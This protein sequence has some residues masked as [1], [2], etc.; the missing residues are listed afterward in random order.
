MAPFQISRP[1]E[2]IPASLPPIKPIIRIYIMY[3]QNC[4]TNPIR[5]IDCYDQFVLL[6]TGYKM[7]NVETKSIRLYNGTDNTTNGSLINGR[8]V[9]TCTS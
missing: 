4:R 2:A 9:I 5:V 3:S 1:M 7:N 6:P 8:L